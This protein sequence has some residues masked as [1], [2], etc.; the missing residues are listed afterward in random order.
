V[1]RRGR[2]RRGV[3]RRSRRRRCGGRRRRSLGCRRRRR[4]R[5]RFWRRRRR[6]W[7]RL[8]CGRGRRRGGSR[9]RRGRGRRSLTGWWRGGRRW[10]WRSRFRRRSRGGRRRSGTRRR[11]ST[12]RRPLLRRLFALL[13]V[14]LS[15][16]LGDDGR[17]GL[18][19]GWRA[20]ELHRR[21]GGRGKQREAKVCHDGLVPRKVLA[22]KGSAW[23]INSQP[24]GWIVAA[25]KR[26][27]VFILTSQR[28]NRSA[29]HGSFRRCFQIEVPSCPLHCG[30]DDFTGRY[31]WRDWACVAH[32]GRVAEAPP[33]TLAVV[34][35]AVAARRARAPAAEFRGWD[36]RAARPAAAR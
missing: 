21:E 26:R 22:P 36:C 3:R 16:R 23:T 35:Q 18:R 24:R 4:R 2:R 25:R 19:L 29:V 6:R 33:A 8:R 13:V 27:K 31:P 7:R 12:G 17:R 20:C 14:G 5:S 34:R 9:R 15:L 30:E 28:L 1:S 10:R 11:G 32:W